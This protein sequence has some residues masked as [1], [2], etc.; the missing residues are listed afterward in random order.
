MNTALKSI[1]FYV[2]S[3]LLGN[4]LSHYFTHQTPVHINI[5]SWFDGN[6]MLPARIVFSGILSLP[7]LI[8]IVLVFGFIKT[9][10]AYFPLNIL[11]STT[12]GFFISLIWSLVLALIFDWFRDIGTWA[13]FVGGVVG[14]AAVTESLATLM[15]KTMVNDTAKNYR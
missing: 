15:H 2:L 13:A 3:V 5:E 8:P 11:V 7:M 12:L 10:R 6:D 1:C 9:Y 14:A 4:W